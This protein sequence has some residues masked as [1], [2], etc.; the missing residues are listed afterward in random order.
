MK[1]VI[2]SMVAMAGIVLLGMPG[3]VLGEQPA[4]VGKNFDIPVQL[5][6][7]L[8][9]ALTKDLTAT[10]EETIKRVDAFSVFFVENLKGPGNVVAV[11]EKAVNDPKVFE[12]DVSVILAVD[13]SCIEYCRDILRTGIPKIVFDWKNCRDNCPDLCKDCCALSGV[14]CYG[15]GSCNCGPGD[16][17]YPACHVPCKLICEDGCAITYK[18]Q[19]QAKMCEALQCYCSCGI[20]SGACSPPPTCP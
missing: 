9:V 1:R 17:G 15:A 13:P 2:C 4:G 16:I 18:P 6:V 3:M 14:T 12:A 20:P 7:R 10:P 8:G 11:I 19:L 5:A